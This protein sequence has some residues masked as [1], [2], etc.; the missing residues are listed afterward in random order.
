MGLLAN[1]QLLPKIS[2]PAA[3]EIAGRLKRNIFYP[4]ISMT[5]TLIRYGYLLSYCNFKNES[6]SCN[7]KHCE[8]VSNLCSSGISEVVLLKKP[9]L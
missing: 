7:S 2:W 6:L 1:F 8:F 5:Y 9:S 3:P 4:R